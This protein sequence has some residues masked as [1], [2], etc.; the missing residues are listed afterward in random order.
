MTNFMTA[1]REEIEVQRQRLRLLEESLARFEEMESNARNKVAS[2]PLTAAV[3][4]GQ[5]ISKPVGHAISEYL[6]MAGG[7]AKITDLPEALAAGDAEMGRY[8]KRAI[9]LAILNSPDRLELRNDVVYLKR[10]TT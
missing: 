1:L 2:K 6:A 7:S 3:L 4:P 5:F 10:K 8:P 9:K